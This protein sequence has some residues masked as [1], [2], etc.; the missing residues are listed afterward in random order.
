MEGTQDTLPSSAIAL[1]DLTRTQLVS[2]YNLVDLEAWDYSDEVLCGAALTVWPSLA[3]RHFTTT[4]DRHYQRTSG[5]MIVPNYIDFVFVCKHQ[6]DKCRL[7]RKR[8]KTKDGTS[9]IRKAIKKCDKER[10]VPDSLATVPPESIPYSQLMFRALLVIWCVVNHRPFHTVADPLFLDIVHMLRPE[11]VVPT[12]HTLS[13][14]LAY[15]HNLAT[16]RIREVFLRM[17]TGVHLAI[18]GWSSPLT[19]SFLGVV[20]FWRTGSTMWRSVLEFIHLTESHTGSYLAEKTLEC[21]DRFSLRNHVVSV[22]LD[23]ASNNNTLVQH[24]ALSLPN[25][26]GSEFRGR[27]MAHITNLAAK[28]FMAVFTRPPPKKRRIAQNARVLAQQSATSSSGSGSSIAANS[29]AESDLP[30]LD[31]L[32]EALEIPGELIDEGMEQH[33]TVEVQKAVGVAIEEMANRF[34]LRLSDAE[35]KEAREVFPKVRMFILKF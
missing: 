11:A 33:D 1:A 34:H 6:P 19:A 35:L 3:Y 29:T 26:P 2:I 20:V 5:G 17:E 7:R 31:E 24:L 16:V 23:N 21:L 30:P 22:C 25:F 14:D 12:P 4:V 10:M 8:S 18:D 13:S 9:N 32:D 28:A 27:C 15:I